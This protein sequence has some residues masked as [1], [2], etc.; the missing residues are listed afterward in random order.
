[1]VPSPPTSFHYSTIHLFIFF[2]CWFLS[3]HTPFYSTKENENSGMANLGFQCL[4][5]SFLRFSLSGISTVYKGNSI[6][7]ILSIFLLNLEGS[8]HQSDDQRIETH[9][10]RKNEDH[11]ADIAADKPDFQRFWKT[12]EKQRFKKITF[13]ELLLCL[14][15]TAPKDAWKL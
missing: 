11:F 6:C 7:E 15:G 12:N 10:R 3:L 1:M 14:S 9:S 4:L 13:W 8:T 2:Y 5:S